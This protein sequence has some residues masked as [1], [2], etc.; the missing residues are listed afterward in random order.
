MTVT[1]RAEVLKAKTKNAMKYQL[2][3]RTRGKVYYVT[4][5]S[6]TPPS[7]EQLEEW[8]PGDKKAQQE[9]MELMLEAVV[10]NIVF[11]DWFTGNP[12]PKALA[13]F[14]ITK[15]E[16]ESHTPESLDVVCVVNAENCMSQLDQLTPVHPTPTKESDP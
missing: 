14:T 16:Y 4:A 10:V 8:H 2:H 5:F 13:N 6:P 3:G 9:A 1:E 15:E 12:W 7:R 11:D